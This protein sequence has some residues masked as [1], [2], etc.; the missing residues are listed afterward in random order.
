MVRRCGCFKFM[1]HCSKYRHQG[2]MAQGTTVSG[3]S[4][5]NS[6]VADGLSGSSE[7]VLRRYRP[8]DQPSC[9]GSGVTPSRQLDQVLVVFVH[10]VVF[11]N[12]LM[13][14]LCGVMFELLSKGRKLGWSTAVAGYV[15]EAP[16]ATQISTAVAFF[17]GSTS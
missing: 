17:G 15:R 3:P 16:A 6:T 1:M 14:R 13:E 9:A 10:I 11:A 7:L 4:T 8:G 2:S 5:A 12:I